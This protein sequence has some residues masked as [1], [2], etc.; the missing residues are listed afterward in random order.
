MPAAQRDPLATYELLDILKTGEVEI[1]QAKAA[2]TADGKSY[3]AGSYV[4]R[5]A[6]PYGAFAKTMLEK[7]EYPDLRLF[8]GGPPKPP[9]DVAGHTL[10]YMLGV[11]VQ[12]VAKPFEASLARVTELK[13]RADAA[14][15][16][17]EVGVRVRAGI[18]RGLHRRRAAAEGRRAGV[19]HG[20][21]RLGR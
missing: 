9:Y 18:E 17:A 12:P 8:P 5:L 13:P 21:R 2:F 20:G 15:G 7:Q 1:D 3:A 4:I 10:G 16:R 19:P 11:D 14:S 6:Q